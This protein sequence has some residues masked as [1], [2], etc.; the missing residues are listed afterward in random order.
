MKPKVAA[1]KESV[2]CPACGRPHRLTR[3]SLGRSITCRQC[4]APFH[5]LPKSGEAPTFISG[6]G[7]DDDLRNQVGRQWL[8][9]R[10][11]QIVAGGCEVIS[12]LG[13][14]GLS[15]VYHVRR[16]DWELDM[17]LKL[18]QAATLDRLTAE[19]FIREASAWLVPAPHPH[20]VACHYVINLMGRP[21]IFMEYVKGRNLSVLM[22]EGLGP[23]Y[24]GQAD[25]LALKLVDLMIQAA[26]GLAYVHSLGLRNLDVKPA[27]LMLEESGRLL[28][29]DFAPLNKDEAVEA[30]DNSR[31]F[32]NDAMT[33]VSPARLMGT[34]QYFSPEAAG[35]KQTG[36][37]HPDLWALALSG[38]ECFLGRRPW[39]AGSMVGDALESYLSGPCAVPVP[40]SL[41]AFFHKALSSH[42]VR[43]YQSAAEMEMALTDIYARLSFGPYPRRPVGP[44]PETADRLNN[45][46]VSFMELGQPAEARRLWAEA[47][48]LAPGHRV[49]AFNRLINRFGPDLASLPEAA[50]GTDTALKLAR[51]APGEWDF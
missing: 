30:P 44:L 9:L 11:G 24:D 37:T 51:V 46:A 15:S 25:E 7:G 1:V 29:A 43:R 3:R 32:D 33:E 14:G 21:A 4:G 18:P 41:A 19:A 8:D 50:P 49:S 23:L 31:D 42:P 5:L 48:E 26:R 10:P 22:D 13:R 20:V 12:L 45:K 6:P 17:A 38:L 34:H 40:L 36:D 47:L 28:I 27:N 35:S 16:H 39:E 2:A